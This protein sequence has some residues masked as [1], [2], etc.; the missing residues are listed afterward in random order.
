MRAIDLTPPAVV[1]VDES[2]NLTEAARLMREE[3]V[4]DL[5]I[6]RGEGAAKDPV[7]I[8]TDRDIVVHAL[9][10]GLD[11]DVI[12][13]ADLATRLPVSVPADADLTEITATMCQHGV[14]RVLVTRGSE[15]AGIISMD[16]VIMATAGLLNNLSDMLGRQYEYEQAHL[17]IDASEPKAAA[18]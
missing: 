5:V 18:R 11:L 7:G 16:K 14:R 13:V 9:A 4:G 8:V 12:T 2:T 10:C 15:L 3:G 17:E 1:S 6:T